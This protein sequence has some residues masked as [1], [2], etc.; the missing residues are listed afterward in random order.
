MAA[1]AIRSLFAAVAL[2]AAA[3]APA[4]VVDFASLPAAGRRGQAQAL[5][6]WPV[7]RVVDA[8]QKLCHDAAA[9]G[10]GATPRYF[11]EGSVPRARSAQALHEWHEALQRVA[12][13]DEHP[14]H[15]PLL[16][17]AL[18]AQASAALT[19]RG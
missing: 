18:V 8:L 4:Q 9:V 14:W 15:E 3:P 6:G 11:P 17:E 2:M 7:P 1:G 12:R 13:H 19:L 5:S 10:A 16:I